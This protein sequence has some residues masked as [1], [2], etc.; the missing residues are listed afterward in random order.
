MNCSVIVPQI[1]FP[2][3]LNCVLL[4]AG[5][6]FYIVRF[7]AGRSQNLSY[8]PGNREEWAGYLGPLRKA[9]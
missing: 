1:Y 5:L 3:Y 4:K 8:V 6:I 7:Q 9:G 2:L